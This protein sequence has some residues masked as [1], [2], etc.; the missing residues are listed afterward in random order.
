MNILL[1][2]LDWLGILCGLY[3][4]YKISFLLKDTIKKELK[5]IKRR[6]K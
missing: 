2:A 1:E 3:V 6:I 4:I 5:S